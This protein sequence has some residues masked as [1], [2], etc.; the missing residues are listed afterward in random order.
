[1]KNRISNLSDAKILS[2]KDQKSINGG[3]FDRQPSLF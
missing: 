3:F 2:K 1:M